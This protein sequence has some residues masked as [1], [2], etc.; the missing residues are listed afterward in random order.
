VRRARFLGALL[1][2]ARWQHSP[3]TRSYMRALFESLAHLHSQSPPVIHRDVKPNNFLHN[4]GD[5]QRFVTEPLPSCSPS[6]HRRYTL[7][8][9]GLAEFETKEATAWRLNR[10]EAVAD[11]PKERGT[12]AREGSVHPPPLPRKSAGFGT[13]SDA[14]HGKST[15]GKRSAAHIGGSDA[16][17]TEEDVKVASFKR[18]LNGEALPVRHALSKFPRYERAGTRGFRAPEVLLRQQIQ[19]SCFAH[20]PLS[21]ACLRRTHSVAR[22]VDRCVGRVVG[23][24][25]PALHHDWEVSLLHRCG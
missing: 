14:T 8:D 19:V 12:P 13:V 7:V 23:G 6:N 15:K 21:A 16:A 3:Q 24:C 18:W 2:H 20:R 1:V 4:Y 17:Q 25:H 5:P 22:C 10:R 11:G 9:F